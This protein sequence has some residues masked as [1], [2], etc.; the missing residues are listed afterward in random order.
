[1]REIRTESWAKW[2]ELVAEQ[3]RSGQSAALFC[4]ERGIRAWH[5]YE[6]KKRLRDSEA[7]KFVEVEVVA[8]EESARPEPVAG[9]AIEIRL[10]K[11]RSLMVESGFD[12]NHLRALLSVLEAEA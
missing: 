2:R 9:R 3:D 7:A 11:G 5:F 12:R 8:C 6:W 10:A 4:R 1:M